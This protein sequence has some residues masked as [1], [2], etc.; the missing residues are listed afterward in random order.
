MRLAKATSVLASVLLLSAVAAC[1]DDD[2]S[3][4]ASEP[5]TGTEAGEE[6]SSL[7]STL[8]QLTPTVDRL[9]GRGEDA[10]AT[11]A[12]ARE[13]I[14]QLDDDLAEIQE[15]DQD[16]PE[17]IESALDDAADALEDQLDDLADDESI[18]QAGEAIASARRAIGTAWDELLEA[19]GCTGS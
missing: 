5:A 7:C 4:S 13:A 8:D 17:S 6:A 18:D 16:L 1:G 19:L 2:D 12:D 15:E 14:D 9:A 10:D 3:G 11:A